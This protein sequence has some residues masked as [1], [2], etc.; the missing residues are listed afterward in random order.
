MGFS[1]DHTVWLLF[2]DGATGQAFA[3]GLPERVPGSVDETSVWWKTY[4][5]G[6]VVRLWSGGYGYLEVPQMDLPKGLRRAIQRVEDGKYEIHYVNDMEVEQ[7]YPDE[8]ECYYSHEL[9]EEEAK[10]VGVLS[11]EMERIDYNFQNDEV[12]DQW[13]EFHA[14]TLSSLLRFQVCGSM[15]FYDWPGNHWEMTED[16]LWEDMNQGASAEG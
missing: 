11:N 16:L 10:E 5:E 15:G 3:E 1:V 12:S 2:E 7:M 6:Q 8:D 9:D 13:S 14:N 4:E